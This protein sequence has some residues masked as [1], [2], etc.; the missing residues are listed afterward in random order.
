VA[1]NSAGGQRLLARNHKLVVGQMGIVGNVAG[2]GLPRIA[3]D[4]GADAIYFNN[5]DLPETHSEM[6][7]PLFRASRQIIGVLDVQ[8]VE[9]NAFG[10]EDIQVLS[11]LAEQVSVAI[12]NARLYE[13]TQ[14]ALVEAETVYRGELRAGWQKYA[15][16]L[17]LAGIRRKGTKSSLLSEPIDLPGLENVSRTGNM[18]EVHSGNNQKGTQITLPIKLRGEVV[19]VLH[20][21]SEEKR[22]WTPDEFDIINAIIERT[23]LSIESSRLLSESQ[24]QASKERIIGEISA[25]VSSYTNQDN[26]LEAAVT[27]IGRVMPGSEVVIQIQSKDGNRRLASG[28]D[29]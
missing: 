22:V 23:A 10:Q 20:L 17:H 7:L 19:G 14:R 3:L 11:T 24:K 5:P 4:T 21:H 16:S 29:R 12:T 1:S 8:S 6:A 15:K 18:Y 2:T 9:P 25:K 27:E 28:E 26:I 13:E